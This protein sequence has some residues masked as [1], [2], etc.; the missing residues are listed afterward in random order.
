[1]NVEGY[2]RNNTRRAKKPPDDNTERAKNRQ[3]R[4]KMTFD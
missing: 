2:N 3:T 1:M 4:F